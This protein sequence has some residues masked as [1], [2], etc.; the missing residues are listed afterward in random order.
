MT[1]CYA[2]RVRRVSGSLPVGKPPSHV[3]LELCLPP[4]MEPS[5][6]GIPMKRLSTPFWSALI[7][8]MF[9]V[10][11]IGIRPS[12]FTSSRLCSSPSFS[13][14]QNWVASGSFDKSIKLWD[15]NRAS[16]TGS[17]PLITL[18]SPDGA[19]SKSSVYAIA[20]DP[21]GTVIASGTPERVIRTWDPRSGKRTAKLV[22][23]TDNIRA[24]LMSAD[25][26]YASFPC[27][28]RDP[29]LISATSY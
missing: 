29:R 11:H 19:G 18:K 4:R 14:D 21:A 7:R 9:G 5:R 8:T 12:I 13:R 20:V 27:F 16:P 17:D 22:G 6:P 10:S 23:H 15:L 24:I 26:K 28:Y 3:S 1:S 25:G 2:T